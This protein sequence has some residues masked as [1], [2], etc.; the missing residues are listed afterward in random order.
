MADSYLVVIE[1]KPQGPFT[2][3]QLEKMNIRS[4][5]FVKTPGMD[6]YKEAHEVAELR[7]FLGLSKIA[8]QP[9]YFATLDIRFL[10]VAIDYVL[11]LALHAFLV[12]TIIVFLDERQQKIIIALLGLALALLTKIF[13]S[14]LMESS[15]RQATYGKSLLGLKVT[16]EL[17]GRLSV[18]KAL[19]RNM[20]KLVSKLT[21]GIGYLSGFFDKKQQCLH[22]KIAGTMV[23]KDRLL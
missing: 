14:T 8:V 4:G 22:D 2:F 1:G 9:Q 16:D 15:I 17:G 3:K 10:A 12:T 13:Y 23:I 6:D 20:A 21:V 5:T 18:N 19:V 11:I 7:V